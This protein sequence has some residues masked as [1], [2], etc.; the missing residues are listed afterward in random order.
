[1]SVSSST[2]PFTPGNAWGP[3]RQELPWDKLTAFMVANKA[4]L[5][6]FQPPFVQAGQFGIG[7][8]NPTFY[9]ED[10]RGNRYVLR[11]KPAGKLQHGAHQID[12]E[13]RVQ[14]AINQQ[15][16][17]SATMYLYCKDTSIVG[18]EFYIMKYLQGRVL[19]QMGIIDL[20]PKDRREC[21]ESAVKTLALLHSY[22]HKA[23]GLTG[24]GKDSGFYDRS[25]RNWTRL[26]N[27]QAAVT[28][29]KTGEKNWDLEGLNEQMEFFTKFMPADEVSIAHL[30]YMLHNVMFHPT[31]NRIVAVLDW[32]LSTIGH[33]LADLAYFTQPFF[34]AWPNGWIGAPASALEGI[35]TVQE[36]LD[37]YAQY[38]GRKNKIERFEYH[39]AFS[40]YRSTVIAQGIAGRVLAGTATNE[41]AIRVKETLPA[42]NMTCLKFIRE[43]RA[44]WEAEGRAAKL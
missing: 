37:M 32:E 41:Q 3:V 9:L 44:R 5:E 20:P 4:A 19:G 38:S 30:D 36:I 40:M 12:R 18:T 10:S 43:T 42:T 23:I 21:F 16:Y 33:P 39:V 26:S 24:Y 27:Q 13:F 15:G 6:N 29:P 28:D 22:D 34:R 25:V 8:S 11:R 31:E 7:Q 1:M 35:P 17:P 2:P 14:R